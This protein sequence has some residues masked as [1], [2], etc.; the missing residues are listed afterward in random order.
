MDLI[1]AVSN[2]RPMKNS[3]TVAFSTSIADVV[4]KVCLV[5]TQTRLFCTSAISRQYSSAVE[6][7]QRSGNK[8]RRTII[9]S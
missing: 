7:E 5:T 9:T 8:S 2:P 4:L 1:S 6:H 3:V